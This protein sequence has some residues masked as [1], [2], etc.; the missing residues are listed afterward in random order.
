M[1]ITSTILKTGWK[2][3]RVLPR[4]AF[5]NGYGVISEARKTAAGGTWKTLRHSATAS[6]AGWQALKTDI[7]ATAAR[8]SR[9]G[10]AWSRGVSAE[11]SRITSGGGT[12]TTLSK[13]KGGLKGLA[14]TAGTA[15]KTAWTTG[16]TAASAGKYLGKLGKFGKFL[17]GMKGVLKPLCKM[18]VIASI[19]TLAFEMPDIYS[20]FKDGGFFEGIKQLGKSGAKVAIGTAVGALGTVIGGPVGGIAGYVIGETLSGMIFGKSW[21]ETHEKPSEA[22]AQG[23]QNSKDAEL[24]GTMPA[25]ADTQAERDRLRAENGA[26]EADDEDDDEEGD[27]ESAEQTVQNDQSGLPERLE[28]PTDTTT[29][30][31][32]MQPSYAQSYNSNPFGF[33]AGTNIFQRFPMG[34]TFQYEGNGFGMMV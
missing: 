17:G 31:P 22:Q 10:G 1:G 19:V 27:D 23:D 30:Y 5:G 12:V 8:S 4:Y 25:D 3:A 29:Y 33:D 21:N 14:K 9:V 34:Y 15:I 7:A 2:Y 20:A 32:T 24:N 11:I 16:S 6:K 13:L 26:V 28:A 18:P